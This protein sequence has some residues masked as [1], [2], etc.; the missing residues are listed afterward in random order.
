MGSL[1]EGGD[2]GCILGSK[3]FRE[4]QEGERDRGKGRPSRHLCHLTRTP[5]TA[6]IP[7]FGKTGLVGRKTEPG[8]AGVMPE[9]GR[10]GLLGSRAG[11]ARGRAQRGRRSC[12]DAGAAGRSRCP[13]R[14]G[15]RRLGRRAWT[16]PAGSRRA[17]RCAGSSTQW[18]AARESGPA[19]PLLSGALFHRYELKYLL[20]VNSSPTAAGCP[21]LACIPSRTKLQ[22]RC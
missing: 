21:A 10:G 20:G 12:Y 2:L 7:K 13:P 8:G 22:L 18:K 6:V 1:L 4:S 11:R 16:L 5:G 9:D 17:A 15:P 14:C 3:L 19:W